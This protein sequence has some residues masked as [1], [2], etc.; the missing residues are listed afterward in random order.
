M[1]LTPSRAASAAAA[2]AVTCAAIAGAVRARGDRARWIAESERLCACNAP[3]TRRMASMQRIA[4]GGL[5]RVLAAQ[6]RA[7]AA[8]CDDL[9]VAVARRSWWHGLRRLQLWVEPGDAHRAATRELTHAM[10][11]MCGDEHR[12]L[13]ENLRARLAAGTAEPPGSPPDAARVA[14]EFLRVRDGMCGR[15]EALTVPP[16]QYTLTLAEAARAPGCPAR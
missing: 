10:G 11:L 15:R 9:R 5:D 1:G 3:V 12:V 2:L 13:W 16:R 4:P 8:G 7:L 14:R 6:S